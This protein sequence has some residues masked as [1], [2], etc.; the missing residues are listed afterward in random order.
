MLS[1]LAPQVQTPDDWE[2]VF[3]A[4]RNRKWLVA[5]VVLLGTAA[6]VVGARFVRPTYEARAIV[7]VAVPDR[8]RLASQGPFEG[9]QLL[10][11]SS[12]WLEVL[13]SD[14][15]LRD[16]VR[17]QRLYLRLK[18]AADSAALASFA[19]KDPVRPG[20]Y[21]LEVDQTG[22]RFA[23]IDAETRATLQ[24]AAVGDS[25]GAAVGFAWV[26]GPGSLAPG[27]A[28]QFTITS[29]G[30]AAVK[31]AEQL[32]VKQSDDGSFVR[33]EW[34]AHDPGLAV[35]TVNGVVDHV[36]A[37]AADLRRQRLSELS[38]I[39]ADQLDHA[40]QNLR[41][42]EAA[43]T[44][45]RVHHA[46]RPPEVLAAAPG[47]GAGAPP[48][49]TLASYLDARVTAGQ[50]ARDRQAILDVLAQGADSGVSVDALS[51]IT[52]VQRSAEL[53]DALK[54][55]TTKQADLRALRFRYADT[56][57]PVQRLAAQV[58]TLRRRVIP[59]L[60]RVLA[61]G[62]E[63]QERQLSQHAEA[64]TAELRGAP[65][66]ALEETRLQRDQVNAAQLFSNLQ[67]RYDEARLAE[68]SSLP[69]MRVLERAARLEKPVANLGPLLILL[70]FFGSLGVG[71]LGAV[72]LDRADPKVRNAE[73]VSRAMGVP[74]LG[75][76]PRVR[77]GG[78]P[79]EPGE[80]MTKAIEALRGLRLSV[81]HAYGA[82]GPI[83][84]TVSSP[85]RGEGKSFVTSNLAQAFADVGFR[86][87]VID[88]DVRLGALHRSLRT[89]RRPG[90]TDV[91]AG[92]IP[93]ETA[94]Q[95]TSHPLLFFM[96]CGSRMHRGPELLSTPAVPRLLTG[97]RG[98]YD[99]VLVDSA[100]LGAGVDPYALGT[101]TGS[102]LLVLR[103]GVSDRVMAEAKVE[104]LHRMPIRLLGVVLND[105]RP[106]PIYNYYSYALTGYE[107]EQE[108]PDG[109]AGEI[110]LP[111]RS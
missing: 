25:V 65:P 5:S 29:P 20:K 38:R 72:A 94:V 7:W 91:L 6:G 70:A 8:T 82:A 18:S 19:L 100:P 103:T 2:R 108:D 39:L 74:I 66:V 111:D 83:L 99:V 40:Q 10:G 9:G 58:D 59:R 79:G 62:L 50:V 16:V 107:I 92:N 27:H 88:G 22:Q 86:T 21:R 46:T 110:L 51:M 73:A 109:A 24:Q 64:L 68:V 71:A 11:A 17:E 97:M 90:L 42:A 102:M 47:A 52:A 28:I 26:P 43:V 84:L 93:A 30:D 85:G 78:K 12:G 48:D 31:L 101:A 67:Q 14:V 75:A 53:N 41:A 76:V 61:G 95:A 80:D 13:R 15:V 56:H 87:L 4:V 23:L 96:G 54:E 33:V 55:L 34:R 57:P 104:V 69:D 1:P 81:Q 98:A 44:T 63:V 60:A 36:V 49:P 77:N 45:F 37:V 105:V 32:R 35:A 89:Q 106:G 3:A